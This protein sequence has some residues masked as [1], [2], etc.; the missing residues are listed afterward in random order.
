MTDVTAIQAPP[1]AFQ[2]LKNDP[3]YIRL[4]EKIDD[5]IEAEVKRFDEMPEDT[6]DEQAKA[7]RQNMRVKHFKELAGNIDQFITATIA[8]KNNPKYRNK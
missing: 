6:A 8:N 4:R 2:A 3:A 1:F 7:R 5:W